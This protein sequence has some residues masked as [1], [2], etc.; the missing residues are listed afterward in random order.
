MDER[1]LSK[2]IGTAMRM[3]APVSRTLAM[4]YL[5]TSRSAMVKL[6]PTVSGERKLQVVV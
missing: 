3:V 2:R 6:P 4:M 5:P 1:I